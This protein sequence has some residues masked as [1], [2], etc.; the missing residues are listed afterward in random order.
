MAEFDPPITFTD[1]ELKGNKMPEITDDIHKAYLWRL[2]NLCLLGSRLNQSISKKSFN[3]KKENA[4]KDSKIEPNRDLL[5]YASWGSKEIEE[6]QKILSGYA[7][8][9]WKKQKFDNEQ[10]VDSVAND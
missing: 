2:G 10:G 7:L 6:R 4:Y 1:F 8:K 5:Q 3:Y 9:I